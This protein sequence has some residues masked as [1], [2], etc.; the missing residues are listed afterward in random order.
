MVAMSIQTEV[1]V[2]HFLQ[3]TEGEGVSVRL[4][5][6]GLTQSQSVDDFTA[7]LQQNFQ[8]KSNRSYAYFSCDEDEVIDEEQL[9]ELISKLDNGS[10]SFYDFTKIAAAKLASCI[11]KYDLFCRGYIYFIKYAYMGCDYILIGVLEPQES[12]SF[13]EKMNIEI[14]SYVDLDKLGLVARID[15]TDYLRRPELQ[16]Y[17]SFVKGRAGRKV[18]DFFM[19]FLCAKEGTDQKLQNNALV[20]AVGN[21]ASQHDIP[22]EKIKEVKQ[23]LA[24]YCK[25]KIKSGEELDT[26]S[27]ASHMPQEEIDGFYS[28]LTNEVGLPDSFPPNQSALRA[29]TKYIGSGGGLTI[30]FD[31]RLLGERIQYNAQTDTLTIVGLPPNLKDQLLRNN[32]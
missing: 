7:S 4:S 8:Q 10:I 14:V 27:V 18:A 17:I 1:M 21:Y 25:E 26:R 30:S 20:H 9:P 19:D 28:F 11:N 31:A 13:S 32:G 22:P 24:T 3:Y 5:E 29:L 15:L 16:R 6:T 2:L 23:E 12:V